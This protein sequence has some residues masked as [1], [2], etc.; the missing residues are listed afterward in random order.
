MELTLRLVL[1]EA[2]VALLQGR[3]NLYTTSLKQ[4]RS[5]A[6]PILLGDAASATRHP[7]AAVRSA[8]LN[9]E[10]PPERQRNSV[11]AAH[12]TEQRAG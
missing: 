6:Q 4:G 2:Q 10:L 1:E 9:Q 11:A 8:S 5:P 3:P 7:A 12:R